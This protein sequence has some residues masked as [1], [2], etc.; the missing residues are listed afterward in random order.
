MICSITENLDQILE[1]EPSKLILDA[2]IDV[3]YFNL[4]L[5]PEVNTDY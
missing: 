5:Y 4:S 2:W 3:S 1:D